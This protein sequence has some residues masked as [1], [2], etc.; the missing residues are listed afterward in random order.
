MVNYLLYFFLYNGYC[1]WLLCSVKQAYIFTQYLLHTLK[2]WIIKNL[3]N[4]FWSLASRTQQTLEYTD[5]AKLNME[6]EHT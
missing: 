5:F 1:H 2:I 3:N 4:F 6:Q